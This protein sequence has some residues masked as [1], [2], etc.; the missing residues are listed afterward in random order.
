MYLG[1]ELMATKR[2]I[3]TSQKWPVLGTPAVLRI[4]RSMTE[5]ESCAQNRTGDES[6]RD[7]QTTLCLE[8]VAPDDVPTSVLLDLMDACEDADLPVHGASI[9]HD[10]SGE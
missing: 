4:P 10:W 8:G 7:V 9:R 5:N 3:A 2:G 6:N 1:L